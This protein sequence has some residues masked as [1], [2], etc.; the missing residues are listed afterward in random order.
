MHHL[1]SPFPLHQCRHS[2][3]LSIRHRCDWN[4]SVKL[5]IASHTGA[6]R[7]LGHLAIWLDV[8][9]YTLQAP[10]RTF[11]VRLGK[12]T[13]L[14]AQ[15]TSYSPFGYPC[16]SPPRTRRQHWSRHSLKG[17]L[18]GC[19]R[20]LRLGLAGGPKHPLV[21]SVLRRGSDTSGR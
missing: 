2:Q 15:T 16:I 18:K 11:S 10:I 3:G 7:N 12:D 1:L 4:L 17:R 14:S 21:A 19:A 5:E 20:D 13:L 8:G 6:K 9:D